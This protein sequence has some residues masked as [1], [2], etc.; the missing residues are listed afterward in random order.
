MYSP[1]VMGPLRVV[2]WLWVLTVVP[3]VSSK[4]RPRHD[5]QYLEHPLQY[6]SGGI[7]LYD[8]RAT[9]VTQCETLCTNHSCACLDYESGSLRCRL[10]GERRRGL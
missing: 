1:T 4:N 8:G 7:M 2:A 6:C 3:F 9:T 10:K 5:R